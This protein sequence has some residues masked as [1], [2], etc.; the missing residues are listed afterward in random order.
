M[1]TL[2]YLLEAL[3]VLAALYGVA[4]VYV[5]AALILGGVL[6]VLAIERVLAR[7]EAT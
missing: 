1:V 6:G 5:P 7:K 4:L 2:L 3:F